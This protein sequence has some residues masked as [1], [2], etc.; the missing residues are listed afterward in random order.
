MGAIAAELRIPPGG[1]I[2]DLGAGTGKVSRALLAAGYDVV[3]VEPL[4]E[5]RALL[6]PQ[7]GAGRVI[8][9]RAEAIPVADR[10]FAA[11][12]MGDSF[13]WFEQPAALVE[14]RRVL[15]P[16]GGIALLTAVPDW[17]RTTW[18]DELGKLIAGLRGDHP[19][20]D[21]PPWQE[22]VEVAGGFT[23]LRQIRLTASV[24]T[25]AEK[26]AD[27]IASW[28]WI[29]ALPAE[30]RRSLD[31]HVREVLGSGDVPAELPIH[32]TVG[33]ASLIT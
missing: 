27:L 17:R 31:A 22:V 20:F 32:F 16:G 28:S 5:M 2:L 8:A 10:S 1:R 7:L 3:A 26:L 30:Q 4:A 13:H 11:V 24:P 9:G 29:A 18:A 23:D 21:G 19:R 33:L 12:T 6:E 15:V 14:I 25:S